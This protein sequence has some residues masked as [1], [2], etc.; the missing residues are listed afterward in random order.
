[1]TQDD[2][3]AFHAATLAKASE[4]TRRKNTDYNPSDDALG[5]LRLCG[6]MDLVPTPVGIAV[7]L[8][9]KYS[10]LCQLVKVGDG[11]RLVND[12][13]LEDTVLDIINYSVL[14]LADL[15][16]DAPKPGTCVP[17]TSTPELG[18]LRRKLAAIDEFEEHS[19]GTSL[20]TD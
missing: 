1:M 18:D 4:L 6:H 8:G 20:T 14:L 12:E 16:D 13:R 5:N 10:R 7:R 9:D 17:E 3:L 19:R 15:A 11:A 2:Y